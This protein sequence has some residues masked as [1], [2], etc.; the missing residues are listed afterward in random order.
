MS[1]RDEH[2]SREMVTQLREEVKQREKAVMER[3]MAEERE[4]FLEEHP[5]DKGNGFYGRTLLTKSGLLKDL[6]VPRTRS[7]DFYLAILQGEQRASIYLGDLVL[8]MFQHGV[9]TRKIKTSNG[10]CLR[11]LLLPRLHSQAGPGGGGG[12]RG[13]E[14]EAAKES[15]LLGDHRRLFPLL[16]ARLLQEG[17]VLHR[18]GH[19]PRGPAGDPHT[20]G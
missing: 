3:L 16:E 7:K 4:L 5:E 8:I 11:G 12:D 18:P 9:S 15:L 2:A 19:R 10:N 6:R 13:L 20:S 1:R 14:D 17:A